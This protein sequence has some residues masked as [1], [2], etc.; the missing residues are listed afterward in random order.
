MTTKTPVRQP[1]PTQPDQDPEPGIVH[2]IVA[3]L[4]K[5][6]GR[7]EDSRERIAGE[8]DTEH[9]AA[10]S[11]TIS[12]EPDECDGGFVAECAEVPGAMGQGDTEAEAL[13]DVVE[14]INA[15]VTVRLEQRFETVRRVS[16][17]DGARIVSV[18][19]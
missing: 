11:L 8:A 3:T 18:T 4:R 5:A 6:F 10:W 14:A 2:T 13:R 12:V 16:S 7:P 9:R 15:I 17:P 19:F 1:H